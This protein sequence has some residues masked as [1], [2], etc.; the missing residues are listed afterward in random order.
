MLDTTHPTPPRR[1]GSTLGQGPEIP[2]RRARTLG[3]CLW[4]LLSLLGSACEEPDPASIRLNE[5]EQQLV[6]DTLELVRLRIRAAQ[7]LSLAEAERESLRLAIDEEQLEVLLGRLAQDP[8]RAQRLM[9]VL[10]DSLEGMREELFS[11]PPGTDQ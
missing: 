6:R 5:A 4:L 10:H 1:P 11:A 9:S 2:R 3:L 8:A 7:D